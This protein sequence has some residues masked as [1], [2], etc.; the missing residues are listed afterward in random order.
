L[1]DDFEISTGL[2]SSF[3]V[4]SLFATNISNPM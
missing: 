2:F 3:L 4:D 1:I